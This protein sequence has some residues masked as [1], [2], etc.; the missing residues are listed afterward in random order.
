[1]I[2]SRAACYSDLSW[3]IEPQ[4]GIYLMNFLN[5]DKILKQRPK[6]TCSVLRVVSVFIALFFYYYF[7][8]FFYFTTWKNFSFSK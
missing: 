8:Y 6:V 1:M 4:N 2:G 3:H 7:F 5:S